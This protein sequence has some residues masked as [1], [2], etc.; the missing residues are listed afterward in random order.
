[1]FNYNFNWC[2]CDKGLV[3]LELGSIV[4]SKTPFWHPT[5]NS[6][7]LNG[8]HAN[9][10]MP[11]CKP[12]FNNGAE[13]PSSYT[14]IQSSNDATAILKQ[15]GCHWKHLI[16]LRIQS[17]VSEYWPN[18]VEFSILVCGNSLFWMRLPSCEILMRYCANF[19]IIGGTGRLSD[20][21][22]ASL[23]ALWSPSSTYIRANFLRGDSLPVMTTV[24]SIRLN[25]DVVWSTLITG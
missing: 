12:L 20:G 1:M 23:M 18:D 2:G 22:A 7:P 13:W 11:F 15:F 5:A 17:R 9:V 25:E 14:R 16:W 3:I 21:W 10:V 24:L 4:Q 19:C 6:P 8:R